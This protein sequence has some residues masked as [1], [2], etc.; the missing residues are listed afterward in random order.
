MHAGVDTSKASLLLQHAFWQYLRLSLKRSK[1]C[2]MLEETFPD[3]SQYLTSFL[4]FSLTDVIDCFWLVQVHVQ[5]CR[6]MAGAQNCGVSKLNQLQVH[7]HRS[8]KQ[9]L[10]ANFK[11][12][13]H[14]SVASMLRGIQVQPLVRV[15]ELV[16]V[17][18]NSSKALRQWKER[19]QFFAVDACAACHCVWVR[20]C[21]SL[22][23]LTNL[24]AYLQC[25]CYFDVFK[26]RV[27][28]WMQWFC[29]CVRRGGR[30]GMDKR[31]CVCVCFCVC[32]RFSVCVCVRV[33]FC[34]FVYACSFMCVCVYVRVRLCAY[35]CVCVCAC[36]CICVWVCACV[37]LCVW[38]YVCACVCVC[39]CVCV[40]VC[41]LL[42][43]F[44]CVCVCVYACVCAC[45]CVCVCV[46]VWPELQLTFSQTHPADS[47]YS[48]GPLL[49]SAL[50]YWRNASVCWPTSEN[51][52]NSN[53]TYSGI[54]CCRG[55][56]GGPQECR[57]C[58][59]QGPPFHPI[60]I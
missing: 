49:T 54:H 14:Y 34:V 56:W 29:V 58:Y 1:T 40:C 41:V 23:G 33:R 20:E 47:S 51:S 60:P 6:V 2:T 38:M 39:F 12:P 13:V 15:F 55:I 35:V 42:C 10:C 8:H 3:V 46:C 5:W 9:P 45:A 31:V 21:I 44:V 17:R 18:D 59:S 27:C 36:V 25:I 16:D 4:A 48:L 57:E 30:G 22:Q 24:C 26:E 37:L 43:V 52:A 32:M 19:T 7:T 50:Q 53:A 11:A 28:R